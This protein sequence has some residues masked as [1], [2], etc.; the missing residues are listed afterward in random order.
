MGPLG[1]VEFLAL[2]GASGVLE[3]L[4]VVL[5]VSG[6]R[7]ARGVDGADLGVL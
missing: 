6:P 7:L 3:V 1:V 2:M 4:W 5:G